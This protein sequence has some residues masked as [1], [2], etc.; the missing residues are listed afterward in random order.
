MVSTV[1]GRNIEADATE[2]LKELEA[3]SL[4]TGLALNVPKTE[5]MA[6]RIKAA[7]KDE[8]DVLNAIKERI[9]VQSLN[10]QVNAVSIGISHTV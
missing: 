5:V 3:V 1:E 4:L 10:K 7:V 2:S 6:S 9:H 8:D